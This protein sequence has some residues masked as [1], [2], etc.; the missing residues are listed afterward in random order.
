MVNDISNVKR[1]KYSYIILY[2]LTETRS[3]ILSILNLSLETSKPTNPMSYVWLVLYNIVLPSTLTP[4]AVS[5]I[6]HH[7]QLYLTTIPFF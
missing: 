3:A 1:W 4:S 7:F 6:A 5:C 2:T